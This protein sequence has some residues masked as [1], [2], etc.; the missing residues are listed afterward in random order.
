[1]ALTHPFPQEIPGGKVDDTDETILHAVAREV[2]EETGLDVTRFVRKVGE[3]GWAE[4][5]PSRQRH[6][7]WRKLIFEVEVRCLDGVVLDPVEHQEFLFA[8]EEDVIADHAAAAGVPLSWISPAN[9]EMNI[10]AFK[11]RG[12]SDGLGVA[13]CVVLR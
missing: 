11:M 9:K 7:V 10:Q 5:H 1:M 8:T 3:F 2:M 6:E 4:F 12:E 13:S